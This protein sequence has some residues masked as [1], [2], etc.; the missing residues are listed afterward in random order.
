M[1]G[2]T[3]KMV[4]ERAPEINENGCSKI[5]FIAETNPGEGFYKV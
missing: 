5:D 4:I 3:I 1:A 2:A